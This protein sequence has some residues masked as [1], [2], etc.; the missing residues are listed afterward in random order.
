[1][2][3]KR[4]KDLM[5]K[6]PNSKS[7]EDYPFALSAEVFSTDQ[8]FLYSERVRPGTKASAPHYHRSIDEIIYVTSGEIIAVEGSQESKLKTGDFAIFHANSKLL[9]YLENRSDTDTTFLNFRR[10]VDKSDVKFEI[11]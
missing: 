2:D 11:D 7:G 5:H 8:L 6:L 9:H 3:I 1:M 4:S 10:N